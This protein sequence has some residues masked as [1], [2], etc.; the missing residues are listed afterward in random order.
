M[1]QFTSVALSATYLCLALIVAL[2]LWRN[3]GGWAAGVAALVGGL[4]LCFAVHGLISQSLKLRA[5]RKELDAVREAQRVMLS[6]MEQVDARMTEVADAVSD[7][8]GRSEALEGEVH[9]LED[10][11]QR[12]GQRLE[13]RVSAGARQ[14]PHEPTLRRHQ[15]AA[16]LDTVREALAENRVDLYLQPVVGLPQRRTVFYESYSRLRDASGRVMMPAEYLAVAEPEG[17]VTSIDN[18][19]L[20]RC[21]QIVRRLAK[22]DRKVGIFCNISIAS[23]AD[24]SFFPQFLDLLAANRDLSGA[25]IFELG[26]AAF[27]ARGSVEARNMGKLADLGFRF[28]LDKVTDLDLDFQDLA[29]SDVK[30]LKIAAP[31]LLDE[32]VETDEGLI[33]R[34]LPDLAA[35]DFS[36]LTR[37]YGVEIVAEKVESERQIV[38][39]LELDIAY[40]QG[41]LFG[42]PRAIRDAVLAEADAPVAEPTRYDEPPPRT[43]GGVGVLARRHV[44]ATRI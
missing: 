19:L 12:M 15:S 36:S 39:I 9:M 30:F 17:L 40:G 34:S 33:L 14:A 4:G 44:A 16:L 11:V 28:S 25:L 2:L 21:V 1:R 22:Q 23:L 27:D 20:F 37:R 6:Q 35:Q 29:R 8:A 13:E 18:L 42:E 32:L 7:D 41:H 3:G 24:E 26:Q 31:F 43:R 38:D 10:L 5:L